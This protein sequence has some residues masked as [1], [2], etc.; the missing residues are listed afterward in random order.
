MLND[1]DHHLQP[2]VAQ[3]SDMLVGRIYTDNTMSVQACFDLLGF[4]FGTHGAGFS[5]CLFFHYGDLVLGGIY[6]GIPHT[7]CR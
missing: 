1:G 6:G 5:S 2:R 4:G 3:P 7:G